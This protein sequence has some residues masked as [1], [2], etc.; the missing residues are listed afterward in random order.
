[1]ADWRSI[2]GSVSTRRRIATVV[3][4]VGVA[5]VAN[6]LATAWPRN[7]DVAYELGPGVV[8]LDVDYLQDGVAVSSAR[9]DQ[10]DGKAERF[11]HSLRLQPGEYE[12]RITL[13]A[14][15]GPAR[16]VAR[17]LSV[18]AEGLVRIDLR[19]SRAP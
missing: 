15:E 18:P 14:S 7:V 17:T 3:A 9:F 11:R 16:E 13:Y 10:P 8:E 1:M 5:I 6:R 2:I 19:G 12:T 4:V